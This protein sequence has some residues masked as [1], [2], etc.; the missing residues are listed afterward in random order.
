[1]FDELEEIV[2]AG[3]KQKRRALLGA[4]LV[5][6][7][8]ALGIGQAVLENK[9]EAQRAAQGYV[10]PAVEGE[11]LIRNNGSIFIKVDP[12][13]GSSSLALGTQ[14]VPVGAGI[15]VHQHARMDE[16]FYVVEGAGTVILDDARY[17]VEKGATVFIPKGAWHGFENPGR[18]LLL[19]WGVT[20]P[21]LEGFFREVASPPGAPPKPPLNLEQLNDVARKHGTQFR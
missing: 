2:M 11:H 10:L 16:I 17:A 1:M 15:R 20:P 19:V 4:A 18:E 6:S 13:K 21:G 5:V 9:A 3:L 8:V 12:T 14:Q 7:I